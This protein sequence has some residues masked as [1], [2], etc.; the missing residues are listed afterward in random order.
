MQD[1]TVCTYENI[2][3]EKVERTMKL[4]SF[5]GVTTLRANG[6]K[7]NKSNGHKTLT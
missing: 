5:Y 2:M 3:R 7:N 6:N 1:V 4:I